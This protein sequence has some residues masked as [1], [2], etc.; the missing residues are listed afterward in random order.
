MNEGD[1]ERDERTGVRH[2][3][4][5]MS[6]STKVLRTTAMAT[7]VPCAPPAGVADALVH[8]PRENGVCVAEA[9]EDRGVCAGVPEKREEYESKPDD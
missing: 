8:W 4:V 6:M 9:V 2:P 7:G 3:G 5:S 1:S